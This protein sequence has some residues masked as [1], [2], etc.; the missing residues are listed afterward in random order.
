M[1]NYN[2]NGCRLLSAYFVQFPP[3][4]EAADFSLPWDPK[5]KFLAER[6]GPVGP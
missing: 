4:W 2:N 6:E 1:H 5:T 3:F